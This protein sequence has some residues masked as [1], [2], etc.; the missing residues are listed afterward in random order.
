MIS[1]VRRS[2]PLILI[3][4]PENPVFLVFTRDPR[5]TDSDPFGD[6]KSPFMLFRLYS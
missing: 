5:G 4:A 1:P 2:R 6:A 3:P